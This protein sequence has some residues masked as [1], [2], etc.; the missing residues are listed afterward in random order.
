MMHKQKAIKV[1]LW[2]DKNLKS[3]LNKKIIFC[4][5]D[6]DIIQDPNG[7]IA[8]PLKL[9]RWKYF[10]LKIILFITFVHF[11]RM[12]KFSSVSHLSLFFPKNF[13]N[14]DD[15]STM[16]YYIGLK[17]EFMTVKHFDSFY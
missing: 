5:K 13:S 16:I 14:D 3:T 10:I 4:I 9:K 2:F 12:V 7:L 15:V 1:N 11:L 17:G 8:Y 6:I